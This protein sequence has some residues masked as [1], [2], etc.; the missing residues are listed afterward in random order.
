MEDMTTKMQQLDRAFSRLEKNRKNVPLEQL[1]TRYAAGYKALTDEI[2][3]LSEWYADASIQA[4]AIPTDPRDTGGNAW[5]EKKVARIREEEHLPG[6]LYDQ[7]R[8]SLIRTLDWNDLGNTIYKL[9]QRIEVEAWEP[10]H[11]RFVTL[12]YDT[13]TDG[14]PYSSLFKAWWVPDPAMLGGGAWLDEAGRIRYVGC[15]PKT[16]RRR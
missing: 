6:R 3:Q 1:Q 13:M 12:D 10:Y 9:L 16:D 11:R 8:E 7:I 15:K 2:R 5:L 4:L 14:R